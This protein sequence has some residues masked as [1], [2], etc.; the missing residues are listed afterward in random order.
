LFSKENDALLDQSFMPELIFFVTTVALFDSFS[1]AQQLIIFILLLATNNPVKNSLSFLL[2][3]TGIYLVF[4]FFGYLQ[5][6]NINDLLKDFFPSL[7]EIS[8]PTYY[9]IQMITGIIF[10]ISG[11]LYYYFKRKS[12]RPSM[13]NRLIA[14]FQN[15]N[16]RVSFIIG[17]LISLTCLPVSIPYFGAIEKLSAAGISTI[18]AFVYISFY[19]LVYI[20]PM[21]ICFAIYMIFRKKIIDIE[22]KLKVKADT[23][24]IILMVLILSGTGLLFIIDSGVYYIWAEPVLK[25]RFLF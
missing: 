3:L 8:D 15:I 7:S 9:K 18:N 2:G 10:F 24:N 22:E 1:T 21:L 20:S 16:P 12:K 13:E 17:A 4:G 14:V 11:P 23:W 25:S 5:V 19:N 6:G